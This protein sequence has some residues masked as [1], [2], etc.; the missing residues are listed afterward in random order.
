MK[1]KSIYTRCF[2]LAA[3]VIML[4]GPLAVR[5]SAQ[6]PVGPSR[7]NA[8]DPYR[9][10]RQLGG[11]PFETGADEEGENEP[12]ARRDSTKHKPRKPLE[13]YFFDDS[14]RLQPNFAWTVDMFRNRIRLETID[15]MM[16]HAQ[17]DYP[18]MRSDVGDAMIG[19]LGAGTIPLNAARHPHYRDWEF[20]EAFYSYGFEPENTPFYNVKRPFTQLSYFSAGQKQR[21]EESLWV[22]HAQNISPSTG[23]NVNYRNRGTRGIY[24]HQGSKD[25]NLSLAFNHTGKR[26]SLHAGYI[27]NAAF[28]KENGGLVN[29]ADLTDPEFEIPQN[30]PMRLADAYNLLKNNRYYMVQS[31]GFPLRRLSEDDL[32]IAGKSSVFFG[33]SIEYSRY[34]K[35]Y[36]DTRAQTIDP[37]GHSYYA[38][39]NINPTVTSDSLFES[40]FSARLF[41]QLQPWERESIVG[42]IDGGV[43]LDNHLY[44]QF[45]PGNYLTGSAGKESKQSWYIYG[46][47]QGRFRRYLLWDA[48]A[49]YIYAGY[50]SGDVDLRANLSMNAYVQ[51]HPITL[52]GRFVQELSSPGYWSSNYFSN[53]FAWSNA[54]ARESQ[55]RL[56][57]SLGMPH[58]GLEAGVF[59]TL[60][61]DKIYYGPDA[62]PQQNS[63]SISLSGIY[64]EENIPLGGLHLNHRMLLQTSS[65]NNVVTAPLAAAYL[66]YFYEFNIVK[67][68]LRLQIGLD[69]WYT[70]SYYGLGYNPATA[71]FY[72][73][74]EKKLGDFP[75]V[76]AFINAKWKRMRIILKMTHLNQ[77][78]LGSDNTFA[79]LHYPLNARV[80]KLGIS[81]GFYD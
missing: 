65:D 20:A 62:R 24:A 42:V 68:V 21:A 72:N 22:T 7:Q 39:W 14:L 11:N 16:M 37:D 57:A 44:G 43:G 74:R 76:D 51:G 25:K 75:M 28:I 54:F 70:T 69:G 40:R 9:D 15:T 49:K 1:R 56:E 71:T 53:H 67:D 4:W 17:I 5:V 26:Y 47:A 78:L 36:T 45:R 55:T 19:P 60:Y 2:Y 29:D 32:S 34:F 77:G 46:S 3:M 59:Q 81:W 33:N 23:F 50:R 61:L 12:A 18:Y 38:N 79:V 80:L 35:K 8:S 13:S 58:L 73:Q 66:S 63:G 6:R 64:L 31:I 41:M 10:M 48:W 30:I 27:Y 52:K